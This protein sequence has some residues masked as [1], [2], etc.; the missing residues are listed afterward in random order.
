MFDSLEDIELGVEDA[1]G[2]SCCVSE[3]EALGLMGRLVVRE[4]A[5]AKGV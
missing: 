2:K 1:C 4:P 5:Q 3:Q